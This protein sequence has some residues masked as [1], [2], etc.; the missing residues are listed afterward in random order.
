MFG[1]GK[2]ARAKA[3]ALQVVQQVVNVSTMFRTPTPALWL[4]PYV[5]GVLY[6]LIVSTSRCAIGGKLDPAIRA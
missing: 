4:D 2:K 5:S 3:A 1:S 6:R